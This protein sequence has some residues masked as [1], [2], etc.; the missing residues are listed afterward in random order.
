MSSFWMRFLVSVYLNSS[1]DGKL[2]PTVKLLPAM[3]PD[4]GNLSN[5]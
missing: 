5:G 2:D 3:G 4:R 1:D